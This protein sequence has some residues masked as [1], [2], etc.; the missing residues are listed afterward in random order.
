MLARA[1]PAPPPRS[2][3]SSPRA[4]SPSL[5]SHAGGPPHAPPPRRGRSHPPSPS[6]SPAPA[7]RRNPPPAPAQRHVDGIS[8]QNVPYWD[9]HVWS[10]G[11]PASPFARYVAATLVRASPQPL[12]YARYV[13][14]YDVMCDTTG[15]AFATFERWLADIEELGLEAD[16]AF[17]YGDFDGNRCP[18]LP[19]VPRDAAQ[20]NGAAGGDA[21]AAFVARFPEVRTIEP[22]N[23]PDD[24][25]GPDVPAATAAS[26]WVAVDVDDCA[27]RRCDAVIAG[28]FNDAP[29]DFVE[30]ER[31]YVGAL[32]TAS[33]PARL[34]P[35]PV[36][37]GQPRAHRDRARIRRRTARP[38]RRSRL[39][40]GDRRLLLHAKQNL[41]RGYDDRE[42]QACSEQRARYL[43]ATLMRR[44]FA[45]V[46]VFYYEFM[47]RDDLPGPCR[48]DDSALYAPAPAGV[49]PPYEP[50]AAVAQLFPFAA[51]TATTARAPAAGTS[52]PSSPTPASSRSPLAAGVDAHG[53][54]RAVLAG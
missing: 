1:A 22:W 48:T 12:R 5:L 9:G 29:R 18:L 45:P 42:L 49:A 17:W 47:Y 20:F 13:V 2:S 40:Y 4:G 25:H 34:G 52:P 7:A 51:A 35:A 16:V 39:V 26:F 19:R 27:A 31:S 10:G 21:V 23:E 43:V 15:P 54:W 41:E 32:A 53:G 46:H 6:P 36:C 24:G 28:D 11:A 44:P 37:G 3:S 14:A 38:A 33:R 8:D 50:R 30:Y